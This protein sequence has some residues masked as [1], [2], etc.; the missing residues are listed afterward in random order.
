[1]SYQ[2]PSLLMGLQNWPFQEKSDLCPR[3]VYDD[4]SW[5]C[6]DDPA[7]CLVFQNRLGRHLSAADRSSV[8][9]NAFN[10]FLMRQ[11]YLSVNNE[12]IEAAKIDGAN[13]LYIWSHLMIL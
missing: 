8:F 1:M 5:L 2:I 6:D 13:H 4:D 11:F 12:L 7:I 9:G 10:I 3:L